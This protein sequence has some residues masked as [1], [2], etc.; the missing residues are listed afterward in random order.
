MGY[1]TDLGSKEVRRG[2]AVD[3]LTVPNFPDAELVRAE[4][5]AGAGKATSF[6][7]GPNSKLAVRMYLD[8]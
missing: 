3:E 5:K 8:K 2:K 7:S 1:E 6:N 4:V